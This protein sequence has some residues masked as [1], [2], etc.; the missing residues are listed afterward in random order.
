MPTLQAARKVQR[1][2]H[3]QIHLLALPD[4]FGAKRFHLL[5]R[6]EVQGNV[7]AFIPRRVARALEPGRQEQGDDFVGQPRRACSLRQLFNS[8]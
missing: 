6:D 1:A 8:A 2:V 7:L 4:C 5:E 3:L